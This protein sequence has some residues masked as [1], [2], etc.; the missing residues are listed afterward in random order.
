MKIKQSESGKQEK[1]KKATRR[2]TQTYRT[3]KT[4]LP[5][6]QWPQT[7]GMSNGHIKQK[8]RKK[9]PFS[10]PQEIRKT[11]ERNE[12]CLRK[13]EKKKHHKEVKEEKKEGAHLYTQSRIK[14]LH[15]KGA[16]KQANKKKQGGRKS[17]RM[18]ALGAAL[19]V[20]HFH[21]GLDCV[22][23][24]PSSSQKSKNK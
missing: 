23:K 3:C 11:K 12:I 22:P 20:S 21:L 18:C 9:Q 24:N 2:R 8:K 13:K 10:F 4:T 14:Q 17:R 19:L 5:Q 6:R 1:K 7:I 15:R 16:K